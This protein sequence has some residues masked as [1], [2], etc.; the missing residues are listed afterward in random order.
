MVAP[1]DGWDGHARQPVVQGRSF[2]VLRATQMCLIPS[3]ATSNANTVT[4]APSTCATRPG[5]PLT[6][7]SRSVAFP[8]VRLASSTQARAICSPPSMGRNEGRGQVHVPELQADLDIPRS[9]I[10]RAQ[11]KLNPRNATGSV[12]LGDGTAY[13][14]L[15]LVIVNELIP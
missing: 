11:L 10:T 9:S 14:D 7:R 4:V 6:V 13:D 5:W 3:P 2:S 12:T 15:P 1:V 8:G